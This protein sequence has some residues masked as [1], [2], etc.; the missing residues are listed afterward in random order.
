MWAALSGVGM[1]LFIHF[2]MKSVVFGLLIVQLP[3]S[4]YRY[5]G[6]VVLWQD[7]YFLLLL[8]FA[9]SLVCFLLFASSVI[10]FFFLGLLVI[11]DM[12]SRYDSL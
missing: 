10:A 3:A 8:P 12:M 9:R 4:L 1:V 11:S 6:I 2:V 5:R 7:Q